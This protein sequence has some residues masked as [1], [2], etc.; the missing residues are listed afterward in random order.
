MIHNEKI[1]VDQNVLKELE[2]FQQKY[3]LKLNLREEKEKEK[4]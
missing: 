3:K 2:E 1:I 4:R